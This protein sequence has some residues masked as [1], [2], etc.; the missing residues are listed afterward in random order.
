MATLTIKLEEID[1]KK[2]KA[3][4]G[5]S[6]SGSQ[7]LEL[8]F[9]LSELLSV[10]TALNCVDDKY[11]P[12][13]E[14]DQG[15]MLREGLLDKDR[16]KKIGV[17]LFSSLFKNEASRRTLKEFYDKSE[18]ERKRLHIQI[19]YN[20]LST[21]S[22][23]IAL[24]PWHLMYDDNYAVF[25]EPFGGFLVEKNIRFSYLVAYGGKKHPLPKTKVSTLNLLLI[26]SSIS[27]SSS[28]PQ[29][30]ISE[31]I[32]KGAIGEKSERINI[33]RP[34]EMTLK[35][36]RDRT[37]S[38][39]E[40]LH[41]IHFDGHGEYGKRC[42]TD[43]CENA[44]KKIFRLNE[45]TCAKCNKELEG[46][47]GYLRLERPNGTTDYV[48]SEDF[49]N[50]VQ[51]NID[52]IPALVVISCCKGA[53]ARS[54]KSVFNGV[55]QRLIEIGVCAVVGS[56]FLIEDESAKIFNNYFYKKLIC[57]RG[58][59]LDSLHAGINS[60]KDSQE[61]RFKKY[62]WYK[63]VL[64]MRYDQENKAHEDGVLFDIQPLNISFA[65]I[66]NTSQESKQKS[67]DFDNKQRILREYMFDF[68]SQ[69]LILKKLVALIFE[70]FKERDI[71]TN[72]IGEMYRKSLKGL[73]TDVKKI[74]SE[75]IPS[76]IKECSFVTK[77]QLCE[78]EELYSNIIKQIKEETNIIDLSPSNNCCTT[79][80]F[81]SRFDLLT[82]KIHN[83]CT[84]WEILYKNSS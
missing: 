69:S 33:L 19:Q 73:N 5:E 14:D 53:Y 24:Y 17:L 83:I 71:Q 84:W 29:Y 18:E 1:Q 52:P 22:S 38:C 59:L 9:S 47:Q 58:S 51:N 56:P 43:S 80:E 15:W 2:F 3:T 37:S 45:V 42:V 31:E 78:Y 77:Q 27:E 10:L 82:T 64:F 7:N 46:P 20:A 36:L 57:A 66:P 68:F 61:Y 72:C 16:T 55:A 74:S 13:Q 25:N 81:E 79:E 62:E 39:E 28:S 21:N 23:D 75:R 30:L 70:L 44:R 32:I 49:A 50:F 26:A 11:K 63:P 35:G 65:P 76:I 60:I 8:P 34:T 67:D 12:S 41:I 6:A 4:F 48:S 40:H 54:G